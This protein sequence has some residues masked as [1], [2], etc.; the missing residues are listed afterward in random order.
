MQRGY[1]KLWRKIFDSGIQKEH[2]TFTLW[3]WILCNVTRKQFTYT[4]RG[5]QIV[6]EPGELVF[7]RNRLADE[8]GLTSQN[9]RTCLK[10]LRKW[11]NLTIRSTN[12]F[13][14]L[15]V[16]NWE[17][18]QETQNEINQ[19]TNQELTSNQPA[20]NQLPT[21]KQEYKKLRNKE[22]T[23]S[24]EFELFWKT[25]PKRTGKIKALEAWNK[26]NG[27]RP[28]IEIIIRK[29]EELKKTDQWSRNN[30]QY[31]PNPATWINQGRWDDECKIDI[32]ESMPGWEGENDT[33]RI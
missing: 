32:K 23:Y 10:N 29:V 19:Q 13:S 11:K 30:G 14:I 2:A 25:Y 26:Y 7:G 18:Y 31:I 15:K 6:L 24:V 3:I 21:T 9:V 8:L 4:I 17:S 1:I 33:Q 16:T 20:T 27:A 28:P 12:R 5:Q 22:I